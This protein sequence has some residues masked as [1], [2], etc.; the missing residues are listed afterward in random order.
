[1]AKVEGNIYTPHGDPITGGDIQLVLNMR[2]T[3]Y[4]TKILATGEFKF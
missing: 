3:V 1:M 4:K 2:P